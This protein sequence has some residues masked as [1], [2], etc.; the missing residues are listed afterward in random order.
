MVVR[1]ALFTSSVG[2]LKIRPFSSNHSPFC[3][4]LSTTVPESTVS[5]L[6]LGVSQKKGNTRGGTSLDLRPASLRSHLSLGAPALFPVATARQVAQPLLA[7]RPLAVD[8]VVMQEVPGA[9]AEL[10]LRAVALAGPRRLQRQKMSL[11]RAHALDLAPQERTGSISA[12]GRTRCCRP[13]VTTTLT[14]QLPA[15][16]MSRRP[17]NYAFKSFQP[18]KTRGKLTPRDGQ[19]Q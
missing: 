10:P 17:P 3:L 12:P 8:V 16:A 13:Q 9:A 14:R 6:T 4:P 11:G 7:G 1:P 2:R 18:T 15:S 5:V 19:K